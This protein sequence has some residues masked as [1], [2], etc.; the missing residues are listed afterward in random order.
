MSSYKKKPPRGV[1]FYLE[2]MI[3]YLAILSSHLS[4][5]HIVNIDII[6]ATTKIVQVNDNEMFV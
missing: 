2:Y 4:I 5:I 6:H 1:V 3:C